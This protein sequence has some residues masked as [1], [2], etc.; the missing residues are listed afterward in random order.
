[1]KIGLLLFVVLFI[2]SSCK[3]K[4]GGSAVATENIDTTHFFDVSQYFKSE[5]EKVKKT[6]FFIYKIHTNNNKKDSTPINTNT[7]IELSQAFLNPDI[8]SPAL[9]KY[10]RE[11]IFHDQTT[12]SFTI[13]Y[14]TLNKELE[15]QNVDILLDE[16]GHTVKNVFLRKFK[17][18]AD[19]SAIE[20][21]SW[22]PEERFQINRVSQL[23]EGKENSYQT[24][25]VWNGKN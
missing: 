3:P 25:V 7:F 22:K 11:N 17:D 15:L 4:N 21:L 24:T 12:S 14:T 6:P 8:N 5:I 19:S 1:M 18:Y 20:Q 23:P 16:D 10:Y 2:Y 9:K 13:S